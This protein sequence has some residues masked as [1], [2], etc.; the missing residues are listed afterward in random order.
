MRTQ[1]L[2]FLALGTSLATTTA[3][4]PMDDAADEY[5]K[6]IPN[7]QTVEVQVPGASGQALSVADEGKTSEYYKLTRTISRDVNVGVY[8][9]LTLVREVVKYPPTDVTENTAVWGPFSEALDPISW[10]V[11]VTRTSANE[12]AY[13]FEGKGKATPSAAFETVLSGV[14][15]PALGSNNAPLEG[16]GEG[17]F[18]LDFDARNR[19]PTPDKDI[20]T[21]AITY[22]RPSLTTP[23][24]I[25][26]KFTQVKDD[27]R[28]GRKVD[29]DYRYKRNVAGSG[30]LEFTYKPDASVLLAGPAQVAVMSRWTAEGSG[31]A[32]VT[33]KGGTLAEGTQATANECWSTAFASIFVQASWDPALKYGT[34]T[35]CAYAAALYATLML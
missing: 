24:Q 5:R 21:A 17:S 28:P 34:E 4:R 9:V 16:F 22:S 7:K 6:G 15:R 18:L 31:R 19:L 29:V 35:Q 10:K 3:C 8:F 25:T 32:D 13:K 33:A 2:A 12:Y 27:E 20:G 14:H 11:S 23:V 26:A 30:E 1:T